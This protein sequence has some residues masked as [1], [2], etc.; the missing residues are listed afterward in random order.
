MIWENLT[1]DEFN[2]YAERG[3]KFIDV[4]KGL[5]NAKSQN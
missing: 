3:E 4:V 1:I 5:V 2:S